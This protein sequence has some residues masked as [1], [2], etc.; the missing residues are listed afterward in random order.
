MWL[1]DLDWGSYPGSSDLMKSRPGGAELGKDPKLWLPSVVDL[2]WGSLPGSSELKKSRPGGTELGKSF[3]CLPHMCRSRSGCVELIKTTHHLEPSE[4]YT[5]F[6]IPGSNQNG[7]RIIPWKS[8]QWRSTFH[9][10]STTTMSS[11]VATKLAVERKIRVNDRNQ[12]YGTP[13]IQLISMPLCSIWN[14]CVLET[15]MIG[16]NR[17]ETGANLLK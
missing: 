11:I 7:W 12:A 17:K 16:A 1:V 9:E 10:M 3:D 4:I 14:T 2:D 6:I 5:K 8:Q 15:N 13:V